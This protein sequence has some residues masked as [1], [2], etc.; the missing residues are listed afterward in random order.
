M[1]M[2]TASVQTVGLHLGPGRAKRLDR[3]ITGV[4]P[5]LYIIKVA[6]SRPE[7]L[8]LFQAPSPDPLLALAPAASRHSQSEHPNTAWQ[9]ASRPPRHAAR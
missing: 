5:R 3:L 8:V 7:S 2:G 6:L 4:R 1:L 9:R